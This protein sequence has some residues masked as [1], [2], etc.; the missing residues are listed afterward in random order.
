MTSTVQPLPGDFGLT[1]I[2]G[3]VGK[4]IRF[5]QWLNGDGFEDFEH[6]FVYIGGGQIIEAEP[7]GARSRN[8]SEYAAANVCWSTGHYTL[9][10]AQRS[11]ICLR[12]TQFIGTPYSVLDYFALA[13]H[14]LHLPLPWLQAYITSNKHVICSQ[15]VDICYQNG[16]VQ[17]F[18]DGRWPGYVTPG[19]LY[20]LIGCKP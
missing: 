2:S 7:G 11:A 4:I 14:R 12:A 8:V 9:T 18:K 13:A 15:L 3:D 19:S 5:G 20:D 1:Q 6:A 10:S 17:L 16:G